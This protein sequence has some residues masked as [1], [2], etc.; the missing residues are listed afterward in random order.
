M[1]C[2]IVVVHFVYMDKPRATPKD[3][4]LWIGAMVSLYVVAF[5][6]GSLLF[7]YIDNVFPDALNYYTDPYSG[8]MRFAMA[9][10]IVL[11]P[12]LVFMMRAIRK[13]ALTDSSRQEIPVR[14][15]VLYLTLFIAGVAVLVDLITLIN[16]FLGGDLTTRF[17]LK[18]GVVLL[19]AGGVFLHILAELKGYWNREPRRATTVGISVGLLLVAVIASGFLILGSPAQVRLSRFDDQKVNDL[20]NIQWQIVNYWQQKQKLPI[21]LSDLSDSISGFIAPADPQ[22]SEPYMYEVTGKLSFKLCATFNAE[23]RVNAREN[24]R[25][26][27]P[28]GLKGGMGIEQSTWQHKSGEVCFDRTIDPEL[29]PPIKR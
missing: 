17:I 24:A 7:S 6:L 13:G 1:L 12:A 5:S 29:Y 26:P 11:F 27:E 3:V 10:L 20:Q 8:E 23:S 22:S 19:I 4:F 18:V 14:R 9:S 25:V 16:Y 15:W 28:A 2:R 21:A